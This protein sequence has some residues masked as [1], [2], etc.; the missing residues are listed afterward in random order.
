MDGNIPHDRNKMLNRYEL[1]Y[2][3]YSFSSFV[4]PKDPL[5]MRNTLDAA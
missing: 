1:V 5:V 4:S 3:C 2:C